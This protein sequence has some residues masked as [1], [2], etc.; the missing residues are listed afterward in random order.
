[1]ILEGFKEYGYTYEILE[2][3]PESDHVGG[4]LWT[5]KFSDSPNDYYDR[6]AMRF[7]KS[8]FMK[9]V[10]DL[11]TSLEIEK[12]GLL[13]PYI[14]SDDE[15]NVL[16][17]NGVRMTVAEAKAAASDDPFKIGLATHSDDYV[18]A[19]W[20]PFIKALKDNVESGW[21]MLMDSDKYSARA[22]MLNLRKT[23]GKDGFELKYTDEVITTLE[24]LHTSTNMYDSA[25]SE[26]VM[27][28][29]DFDSDDSSVQWFCVWGGSEEI[30]HRMANCLQ[31]GTILRGKRVTAIAPLIEGT[32]PPTSINV[33]VAGGE[34]YT[35]DHV[36]STMPLSCLGLV[37]IA[38]WGLS[39]PTQMAIRALHYDASVKIAIRF[40]RR[41]WEEPPFLQRGGVSMSDRPTRVVV[42]PSYGIGSVD[43]T[44]IVSYTWSQDAL[45]FGAL[46]HGKSPAAARALV[47]VILRD[48]ADI[49]GYDLTAEKLRSWMVGLISIFI[50]ANA[51][52]HAGAFALFGPSQF[53]TLYAELLKPP[54]GLLHF[55]GEATSIHHAWLVGSLNSAYRSVAEIFFSE[56]RQDLADILEETWGRRGEINFD[57]VKQQVERGRAQFLRQ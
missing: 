38:K 11:F 23:E 46:A 52:N 43:G 19:A 53:S 50:S 42:Y 3:E 15:H 18:N 28:A 7:P 16:Y 26:S 55:A 2:A 56:G 44:M 17:Y 57:L 22:Y 10:F 31:C 24:T 33:T 12:D 54:A 20:R 13:V 1:M 36:I 49:H 45:R 32:D 35:Y 6:G 5:H 39:W 51:L 40:S 37:D 21:D 14:L 47:D 48:L 4:R 9:P 27:R 8:D 41:W 25:L 34:S 29:L 30:A